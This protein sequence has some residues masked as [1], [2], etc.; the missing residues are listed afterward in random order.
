MQ[1]IR[2]GALIRDYA[3]SGSNISAVIIFLIW[4]FKN[5]ITSAG[6]LSKKTLGDG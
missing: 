4:F 3:Y 6:A 5:K 1:T 2:S